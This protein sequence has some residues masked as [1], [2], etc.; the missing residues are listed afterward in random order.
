MHLPFRQLTSS[1]PIIATPIRQTQNKRRT[2]FVSSS[3]GLWEAPEEAQEVHNV[4]DTYEDNDSS[5]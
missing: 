1:D 4:I 3:T 5:D 2:N